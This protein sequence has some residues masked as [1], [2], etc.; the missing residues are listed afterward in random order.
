[1]TEDTKRA[2]EIIK[3]MA[4]FLKLE[5]TADDTMM[6]VGGKNIGIGC[7]STYAT[8]MEF[9]GYMICEYE[10]RFRDLNLTEKQIGSIQRYWFSDEQIKKFRG[11]A[12]DSQC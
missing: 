8:V 3:P 10:Y 9:I 7:N 2:L 1:M 6:Y 4:D 12:D 11:G 5:V